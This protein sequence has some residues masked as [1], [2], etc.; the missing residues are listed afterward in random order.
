MRP[1][2]LG[3][4]F[5]SVPAIACASEPAMEPNA[6]DPE[7][8]MPTVAAESPAVPA[9][10]GPP[11]EAEP[12][13]SDDPPS[14]DEFIG[15]FCSDDGYRL[16]HTRWPLEVETMNPDTGDPVTLRHSRGD[17]VYAFGVL[18]A[19]YCAGADEGTEG[20]DVDITNVG[21][22]TRTL[23][24]IGQGSDLRSDFRFEVIGDDW[25]LVGVE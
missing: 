21:A 2:L 16:D 24:L 25:F 7:L 15:R 23:R 14:F 9:T 8:A 19:Y 13:A 22:T 4:L 5:A 12:E 10:V 1:L 20:V 18:D 17:E 3:F 6:I 11:V